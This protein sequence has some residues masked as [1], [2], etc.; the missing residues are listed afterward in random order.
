MTDIK[1][2]LTVHENPDT[3]IKVGFVVQQNTGSCIV[4]PRGLLENKRI[5]ELEDKL[6]VATAALQ[7]T[8]GLYC[9]I[10]SQDEGFVRLS[11]ATEKQKDVP[12]LD[13]LTQ[14]ILAELDD[15]SCLRMDQFETPSLGHILEFIKPRTTAAI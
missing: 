7:V 9:K 8:L 12:M 5:K 6:A 14:E 13:L 11:V 15:P 3:G 2:R 1:A 10:L 4:N